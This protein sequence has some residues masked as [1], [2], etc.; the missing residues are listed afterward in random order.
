MRRGAGPK[1]ILLDAVSAGSQQEKVGFALRHL[2]PHES[3]ERVAPRDGEEPC[4]I[5]SV[6]RHWTITDE[7][8]TCRREHGPVE[9]RRDR[10]A[11]EEVIDQA[12][13]L[14]REVVAPG[15]IGL[16]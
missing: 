4:L 15:A 3:S 8:Q 7:P 1:P 11:H 9:K 16:F 6:L 5:P 14:P 10:I 12:D 13:H 2:V